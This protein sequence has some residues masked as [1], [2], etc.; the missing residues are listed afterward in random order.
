MA[1]L[2]TQADEMRKRWTVK[3]ESVKVGRWAQKASR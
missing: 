1:L 2:A 3:D